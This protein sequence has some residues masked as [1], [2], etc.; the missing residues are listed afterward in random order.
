MNA[1]VARMLMKRAGTLLS[2]RAYSRLE[3]RRKL[4]KTA[5]PDEVDRVLNRLEQLNLLNDTEYAYNFALRRVQQDGWSL[6]KVRS[7]LL[8]REVAGEDVENSLGRVRSEVKEQSTISAYVQKRFSRNGMPSD[9]KGVVKLIT[10]LRHRGFDEADILGALK[11]IV[12]DNYLQRLL[13]GE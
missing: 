2:R 10:H 12:P 4:V 8:R 9:L 3:L 5:N 7:A 13:T 6:E 1:E 11:G